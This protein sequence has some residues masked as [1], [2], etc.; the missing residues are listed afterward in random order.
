MFIEA[1][2]T[3]I[4]AGLIR[5]FSRRARHQSEPDVSQGLREQ[6]V[7]IIPDAGSDVPE[8]NNNIHAPDD[9]QTIEHH[10][11]QNR[12]EFWSRKGYHISVVGVVVAIVGVVVA[13]LVF[14]F[15]DG[16]LKSPL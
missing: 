6:I 12:S 15:G 10:Q 5:F 14:L 2:I 7:N 16:I 13:I 1:L 11:N 4:V 9:N 8:G 3:L